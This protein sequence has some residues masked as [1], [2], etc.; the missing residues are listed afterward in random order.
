MPQYTDNYPDP[1]KWFDGYISDGIRI[2]RFTEDKVAI[3]DG[4]F[5]FDVFMPNWDEST[6]PGTDIYALR[7]PPVPG[8][9]AV[10]IESEDGSLEVAEA[11]WGPV[12]EWAVALRF[13][14]REP[15]H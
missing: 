13:D 15:L 8:S 1:A 14:I 12:A 9:D 3:R 6:Y 2:E 10:L 5:V 4:K 11:Q 7:F